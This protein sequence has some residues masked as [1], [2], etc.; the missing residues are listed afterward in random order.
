MQKK[1]I[2]IAVSLLVVAGIVFGAVAVARNNKIEEYKQNKE[3]LPLSFTYTAHTGCCGTA[4]NSL[5]SI[6]A[7]VSFGAQIVEFDLSF[8]EQENPILC[9]DEP[10]GGEVTLEEAFAKISQY[11]GLMVNVDAKSCVALWKVQELASE[12]NILNRIFF[13]G[14]NEE[15]VDS[16]KMSAPAVDYYLNVDVEKPSEHTEEYLDSLVA[17]VKESGAIGINFNKNSAS[18]ELVQVFHENDLLVSI[19][20]VDK[21]MEM[22]EILSYAPDNIT[23]KNPDKLQ[24]I[25]KEY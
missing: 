2:I 22:Y 17:K 8:D 19:F 23:T 10:V 3:V 25:L 21:E 16:V 15:D 12:Y 18:E 9:H 4:D 14:I 11:E 13:T 7:G 6:E 20:T 24:L 5:E 1:I